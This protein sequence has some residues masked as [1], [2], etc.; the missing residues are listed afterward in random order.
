MEDIL[1]TKEDLERLRTMIA[2]GSVYEM[3]LDQVDCDPEYFKALVKESVPKEF[4]ILYQTSLTDLAL[5]LDNVSIKG[6]LNFRFT[7]GK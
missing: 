6:L 1:F 4:K 5:M 2:P 7:I 3:F